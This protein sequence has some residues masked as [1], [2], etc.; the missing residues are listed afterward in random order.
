[1]F[2]ADILIYFVGVHFSHNFKNS[3]SCRF[4]MQFYPGSIKFRLQ[5]KFAAVPGYISATPWRKQIKR[6]VFRDALSLYKRP[7]LHFVARQMRL[8]P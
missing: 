6:L 7:F 1:M 3:L 2:L 4:S 8:D 5:A